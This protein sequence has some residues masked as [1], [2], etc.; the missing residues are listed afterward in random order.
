MRT[1]RQTDRQRDR[2]TD[3][4]TD[5]KLTVGFHNFPNTRKSD[6]AVQ[7]GKTSAAPIRIMIFSKNQNRLSSSEFITTIIRSVRAELRRRLSA[8]YEHRVTVYSHSLTCSF[9]KNTL[10]FNILQKASRGEGQ[11]MFLQ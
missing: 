4:Q 2:Q 3:R 8:N 1:D 10:S 7:K 5:T 6:K 9:I 11:P